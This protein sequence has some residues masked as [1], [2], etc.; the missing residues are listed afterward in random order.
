MFKMKSFNKTF[1]FFLAFVYQQICLNSK[2]S[3]Y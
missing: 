1:E 2:K 3:I